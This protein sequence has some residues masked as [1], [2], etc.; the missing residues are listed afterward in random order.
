MKSKNDIE[1]WLNIVSMYAFVQ[2]NHGDDKEAI[3]FLLGTPLYI[4]QTRLFLPSS[5]QDAII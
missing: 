2:D 1:E 4:T 5:Y 3:A